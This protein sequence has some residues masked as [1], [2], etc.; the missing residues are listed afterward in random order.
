[1]LCE[2]NFHN[3]LYL[4]LGII[5]ERYLIGGWDIILRKIV[6]NVGKLQEIIKCNNSKY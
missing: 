2:N 4:H 1:M 3:H 6:K 5:N